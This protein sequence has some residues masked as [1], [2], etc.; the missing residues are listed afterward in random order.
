MS[1]CVYLVKALVLVLFS[2]AGFSMTVEG[3][4]DGWDLEKR[5]SFVNVYSRDK[6][7]SQFREMKA[8]A[9]IDTDMETLLSI[10]QDPDLYY[11]WA[12]YSEKM[13]I[14]D[15]PKMNSSIVYT[16]NRAMWPIKAREAVIRFDISQD[17][18]S[19]VWINMTPVSGVIA[20]SSKVIR[21][22]TGEGYWKLTPKNG[23]T[24]VEYLIHV[25]PGGDVPAWMVNRLNAT[26]IVQAIKNLRSLT[27]KGVQ[28]KVSNAQVNYPAPESLS[29]C[30]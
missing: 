20:E 19:N 8:F 24:Y 2:V 29:T 13:E 22:A 14:V 9:Q 25:D 18:E 3:N 7:G 21:I 10:L 4:V 28:P 1:R 5:K 15:E 27:D 23:C 26:V 16:L 12:P 11:R 17:K 6:A 30:Q